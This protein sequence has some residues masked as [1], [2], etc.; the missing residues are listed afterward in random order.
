MVESFHMISG[1]DAFSQ[2]NLYESH[3]MSFAGCKVV[4]YTAKPTL[5]DMMQL[6]KLERYHGCF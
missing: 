3:T 6:S 2:K 4:G 1:R 5:V